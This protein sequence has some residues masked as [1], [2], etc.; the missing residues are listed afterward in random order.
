[1]TSILKAF[2][3]YDKAKPVTR[4]EMSCTKTV[5]MHTARS[6]S[7]VHY[8][9]TIKVASLTEQRIF[10]PAN[11]S[12]LLGYIK[13]LCMHACMNVST[14][15]IYTPN[16]TI[17]TFKMFY[18]HI[19]SD[20]SHISSTLRD[21][22]ECSLRCFARDYGGVVQ[23][24]ISKSSTSQWSRICKSQYYCFIIKLSLPFVRVYDMGIIR[25]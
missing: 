24:G 8:A 3:L 11:S 13:R 7:P 15:R 21:H 1:M 25:Y 2:S 5:P 17:Y 23:H 16:K 9:R 22:L 20:N 4:S 10:E 6:A 12:K 14:T 18:L 19:S